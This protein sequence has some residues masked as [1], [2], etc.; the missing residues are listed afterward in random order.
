MY[1]A[2]TKKNDMETYQLWFIFGKGLSKTPLKCTRNLK[3]SFK[4][5]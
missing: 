5:V 1:M 3:I 2:I 4:I